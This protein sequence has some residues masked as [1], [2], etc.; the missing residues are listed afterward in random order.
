M[1]KKTRKNYGVSEVLGTILLLAISVTLFSTVYAAF[2]SI[3]PGPSTPAV[4]IVG[5]IENNSLVL[6]HRGG[7]SLGL[8][9]S[10]IIEFQQGLREMIIVNDQDF[11]NS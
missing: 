11:L 6:E 9:T 3:Q 5:T 1:L 8:N 10:L 2:F 4:N 7:E